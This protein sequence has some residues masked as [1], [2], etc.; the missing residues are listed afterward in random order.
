MALYS[1]I[2]ILAHRLISAHA[3]GDLSDFILGER[4][5][6]S[7]TVCHKQRGLDFFGLIPR[8]RIVPARLVNVAFR[9]PSG[10]ILPIA[11]LP[12]ARDVCVSCN[13]RR[14]YPGASVIG[15]SFLQQYRLPLG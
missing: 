7:F 6:A 13:K 11:P 15:A 12:F 14:N 1:I 9:Q 4:R 8:R 2:E 10:M 3:G 5:I